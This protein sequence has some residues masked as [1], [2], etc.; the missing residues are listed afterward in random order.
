MVPLGSSAPTWPD[1]E[2]EREFAKVSRSF[3]PT[4]GT[5]LE[6]VSRKTLH[7]IEENSPLPKPV[8]TSNVVKCSETQGPVART[9]FG[10]SLRHTSNSGRRQPYIAFL[11][12]PL[13]LF[14]NRRHASYRAV[15][16]CLRP[17]LVGGNIIL[18][19]Q[20]QQSRIVPPRL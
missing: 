6:A 16:S 5:S 8:R 2:T 7:R 20:V 18:P 1:T 4:N 19:P 10:M 15:S 9:T 13:R 12:P 17:Y 11:S 14:L 3:L